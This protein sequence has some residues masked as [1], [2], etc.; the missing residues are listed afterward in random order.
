MTLC[1]GKPPLVSSGHLLNKK[2]IWDEVEWNKCNVC[3]LWHSNRLIPIGYLNCDWGVDIQDK[4][5]SG[6]MLIN[7]RNDIFMTETY[8]THIGFPKGEKEPTETIK[9]CAEREFYEETG[10]RFIINDHDF[11][12]LKMNVYKVSYVFYVIKTTSDIHTKPTDTKEVTSYG[13][14][15]I[16]QVKYIR[17]VSTI[18]KI[19]LD[20]YL[21][22]ITS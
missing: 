20:L 11:K 5:K 8:H 1:P 3:S 2:W 19:I 22:H 6:I 9:D 17:K 4:I 21:T 7:D 18:S 16:E 10:T 13:W 12:V 15:N 14:V